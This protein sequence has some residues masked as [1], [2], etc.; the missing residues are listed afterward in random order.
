MAVNT[1]VGV[2][3]LFDALD[4]LSSPQQTINTTFIK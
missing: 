1:N 2:E 4:R 3:P